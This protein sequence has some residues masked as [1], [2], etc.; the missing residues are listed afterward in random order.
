MHGVADPGSRADPAGRKS[1]R[2]VSCFTLLTPV[3]R[4]SERVTK[5][6]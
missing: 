2:N 4:Y 5:C 3:G 6:W 1:V